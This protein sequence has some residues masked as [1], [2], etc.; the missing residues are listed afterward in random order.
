[1]RK[2]RIRK[3]QDGKCPIH[4]DM[5]LLPGNRLAWHIWSHYDV[6]QIQP[7]PKQKPYVRL[8][9]AAIRAIFEIEQIE[10]E[11]WAECLEK[12]Q[13]IFDERLKQ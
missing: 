2:R 4:G 9:Y 6:L 3:L 1:M 5:G 10:T 12:L 13:L 8:D 11:D 7:L